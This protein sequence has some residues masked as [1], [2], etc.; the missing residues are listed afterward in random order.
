M[1]Q[2]RATTLTAEST[3]CFFRG[4]MGC[5]CTWQQTAAVVDKNKWV[6]CQKQGHRLQVAKYIQ[7][8]RSD[9]E[10]YFWSARQRNQWWKWLSIKVPVLQCPPITK[11]VGK[12]KGWLNRCYIYK[13]TIYNLFHWLQSTVSVNI[14]VY[15]IH[16]QVWIL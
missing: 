16:Q 12:S 15:G 4:M 10:V 14:N 6:H 7:P 11:C 9:S 13:H 1:K 3:V 5:M 8:F 2:L